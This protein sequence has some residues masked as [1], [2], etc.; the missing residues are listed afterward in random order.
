MPSTPRRSLLRAIAGLIAG[1][2]GCQSQ[3]STLAATSSQAPSPTST[4]L[5]TRTSSPTDT[6]T[7]SPRPVEAGQPCE[8]RWKPSVRWVSEQGGSQPAVTDDTVYVTSNDTVFALDADSGAVQWHRTPESVAASKVPAIGGS[9]VIVNWGSGL[10]AYDANFGHGQWQFVPPGENSIV[11]TSPVITDG[12]VFVTAVGSEQSQPQTRYHRLY[13]LSLDGGE[14]VVTA[15]LPRDHVSKQVV[16]TAGRVYVSTSDAHLLAFDPASGDREWTRQLGSGEIDGYWHTPAVAGDT[17]YLT[18]AG[19]L[20]AVSAD[21]GTAR[22]RQPGD[23]TLDPAV[24]GNRLYC[25]AEDERTDENPLVALDSSSG[26]ELWRAPL[27]ADSVGGLTATNEDVF[28]S[29]VINDQASTIA[30]D[31]DTGCIFGMYA[32]KGTGQ[33]AVT[34]TTAVVTDTTVYFGRHAMHAVSRP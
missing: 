12:R 23:F 22:W 26:Q 3:P 8:K 11:K 2:A 4:K 19:T 25:L 5:P 7:A 33:A 20:V 28:V 21:D 29:A 10:T 16:A 32:G 18:V 1:L 13:G 31:A 14:P 6:R 34:Y 24:G 27:G 17:L 15:D 9:T 30:L